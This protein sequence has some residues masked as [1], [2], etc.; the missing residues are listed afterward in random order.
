MKPG[1]L[2]V[3]GGTGGHLSPG[4][5]LAAHLQNAGLAVDFLSLNKNSNYPD[6]LSASYPVH[7]YNAPTLNLRKILIFPIRLLTAMFRAIPL[8]RK[9][10]VIILMGGFPCLPAGLAAVL[11]R[12]PIYL[13]EQ[14]AVLGRANRLFARFARTVFLNIPLSGRSHSAG[15]PVVGNPLRQS[16]LGKISHTSLSGKKKGSARSKSSVSGKKTGKDSS[17]GSRSA[18]FSSGKGLRILVA[19]GSQGA[20]QINEMILDLCQRESAFFN[21]YRWVLQAGLRNEQSM[22]ESFSGKRNIQVIGFDPDIHRFYREADLIVCRAGAGVL[23]EAFLFGLPMV[24]I[25]YPFATDSHQKENAS[26]AQLAGAA[27]MIDTTG[28]AGD[29]L[30]ESLAS[31]EGKKL[32]EMAGISKSLARPDASQKILNRILADFQ[33][34]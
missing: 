28:S 34:E 30:Y 27:L 6:L 10:D 8:V 25:P 33:S 3:A 19:G 9:K 1:I 12:I 31:L 23:T 16:F 4:T 32:K 24:L 21:R 15:W 14:N 17:Y 26:Y 11:F 18:S 29:L 7:F 5:A 13:C 20:T 22:K 2:V